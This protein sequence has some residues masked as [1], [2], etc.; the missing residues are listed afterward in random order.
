MEILNIFGNVKLTSEKET[1]KEVCEENNAD[2]QDA[3]LQN[4]DLQNADLQNADL[5][6]ADLQNANLRFADL[7]NADLQNANLQNANLQ[8]ANLRHV[9]ARHLR[10]SEDKEILFRLDCCVWPVTIFHGKVAIGCRDF[11]F[12]EILSMDEAE[13]ESIHEGAG[14]RWKRFGNTLK[15]AISDIQNSGI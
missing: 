12:D 15:M 9:D 7:Q 5:Q 3:D 8:D 10:L 4:A 2:L 14:K 6:N 11:T 13:A 1:L